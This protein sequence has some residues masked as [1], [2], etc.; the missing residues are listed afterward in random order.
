[1][2]LKD[3]HDE[4]RQDKRATEDDGANLPS[5]LTLTRSRVDPLHNSKNVDRRDDVEDLEHDVP[6]YRLDEEVE[7]TCA[8]DE[9]VEDLRD[10]R[11]ALSASVSMDSEDEDAF[12]EGV[13]QVAQDTE[14][15]W[16]CQFVVL[17]MH[18]VSQTYVP[19]A[20]C[21]GRE[22]EVSTVG[23]FAASDS[24][25]REYEMRGGIAG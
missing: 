8:E 20:H 2:A 10:E 12:G 9:G 23:V 4:W 13:G 16:C 24:G 11:D 22:K 21:Q 6:W 19:R 1:M 17:V 14:E 18:D 3:E 25:E 15:L 7:V 5:N